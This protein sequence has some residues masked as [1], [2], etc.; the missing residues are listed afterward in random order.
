MTNHKYR[1][2]RAACVTRSNLMM[3][4]TIRAKWR[5]FTDIREI[6]RMKKAADMDLQGTC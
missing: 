4:T 1:S 5:C 2:W 6:K 3:S